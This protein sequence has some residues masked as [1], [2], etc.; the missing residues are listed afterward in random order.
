MTAIYIS[1]EQIMGCTDM[2]HNVCTARLINAILSNDLSVGSFD[3]PTDYISLHIKGFGKNKGTSAT[4]KVED[5]FAIL[6]YINRNTTNTSDV[7]I[8]NNKFRDN[9]DIKFFDP[10]ITLHELEIDLYLSNGTSTGNSFDNKFEILLETTET[11][12][13]YRI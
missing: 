3:A 9:N 4:D 10:P 12:R 1:V 8:Y 5:S 13:D 11:M 6:D 2:I 7:V